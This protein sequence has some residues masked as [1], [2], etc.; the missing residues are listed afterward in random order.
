MSDPRGVD[1]DLMPGPRES[2]MGQTMPHD[3][4]GIDVSTHLQGQ[5]GLDEV[6]PETTNQ[7]N[8]PPNNKVPF[9]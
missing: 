3:M 1:L 2:D 5:R 6:P 9:C 4:L 8:T 7:C